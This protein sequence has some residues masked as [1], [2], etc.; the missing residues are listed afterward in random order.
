MMVLDLTLRIVTDAPIIVLSD[1]CHPDG[2]QHDGEFDEKE[3]Q[4][5]V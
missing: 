5:H 4:G 1:I 3:F 2:N